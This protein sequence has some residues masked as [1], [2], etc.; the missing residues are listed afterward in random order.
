MADATFAHGH[1]LLIGIGGQGIGITACDATA[2]RDLL[3]D[4]TRA[5]YPSAQVEL[6]TEAGADAPA[7]WKAF[8]RLHESVSRDPEATT[9]VYFSGHGGRFEHPDRPTKYCL[10]PHGYDPERRAQTAISGDEFTDAIRGISGRKLVVILDCCHAAGMPSIKA[11]GERFVKSP[12]VPGLS[13]VLEKGSG[14]VVIASC[15]EGEKS[16]FYEGD[17]YSVFTGFFLEALAGKGAVRK[18]GFARVLDVLVYLL[19]QVPTRAD[20]HPVVAHASDLDNFVLCHAGDSR[21]FPAPK[22]PGHGPGGEIPPRLR[23]RVK[24]LQEEIARLEG[25]LHGLREEWEHLDERARFLR[26]AQSRL[27]DSPGQQFNLMEEIRALETR[28]QE[29]ERKMAEASRSIGKAEEAL[30]TLL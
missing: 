29:L 2:L 7:I 28:K 27:F 3:I 6:L 26:L 23:G 14:R 4:R 10:I 22:G 30:S 1:A 9:V 18:D 13:S 12:E 19:D 5:A 17:R 24:R 11:P 15:R 21:E 25:L 8:C 16:Y 20:Q